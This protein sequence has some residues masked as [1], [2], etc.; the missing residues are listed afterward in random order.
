MRNNGGIQ[1]IHSIVCSLWTRLFFQSSFFHSMGQRER[2]R[3]LLKE[4]KKKRREWVHGKEGKRSKVRKHRKDIE[5]TR[6]SSLLN[7]SASHSFPHFLQYFSLALIR[8]ERTKSHQNLHSNIKNAWDYSKSIISRA[9]TQRKLWSFHI[10][11]HI[12]VLRILIPFQH[13][14]FTLWSLFS[15]L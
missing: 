13:S 15:W 9:L 14:L 1:T 7:Q 8:K 3:G 12:T 2:E 10:N 4:I 5:I 6:Y 11:I